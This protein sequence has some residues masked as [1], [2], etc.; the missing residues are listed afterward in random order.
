MQ[1]LRPNFTRGL[2]RSIVGSQREALSKAPGRS[3]RE[4]RG[5]GQLRRTIESA[6]GRGPIPGVPC[7][8]QGWSFPRSADAKRPEPDDS[9]PKQPDSVL[10][11]DQPKR[12]KVEMPGGRIGANIGCGLQ[13]VVPPPP[14]PDVDPLGA[15]PKWVRFPRPETE[16]LGRICKRC[17][18]PFTGVC[19]SLWD[20]LLSYSPVV[21]WASDGTSRHDDSNRQSI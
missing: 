12:R 2:R 5:Q 6:V 14:S 10:E 18:M 21:I 9:G 3:F 17:Q 4:R 7:V 8:L 11:P 16:T 20:S 13:R 15:I 1:R 19:W